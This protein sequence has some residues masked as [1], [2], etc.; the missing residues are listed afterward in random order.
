MTFMWV[1]G[2]GGGEKRE[3]LDSKVQFHQ[4][5]DSRSDFNFFNFYTWSCSC[6]RLIFGWYVASIY[7]HSIQTDIALILNWYNVS[8]A[9]LYLG[10][11]AGSSC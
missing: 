2:G 4:E 9:N 1:L 10:R 11:C 5:A 8:G 6:P 7:I 3:K